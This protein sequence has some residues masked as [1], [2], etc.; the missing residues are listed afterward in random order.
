[1]LIANV[2]ES[3]ARTAHYQPNTRF[4]DLFNIVAHPHVLWVAAQSIILNDGANTPGVDGITGADFSKHQD[5]YTLSLAAELTAGT[6]QPGPVKRVYIPK[7]DGTLRP[8][9]IPTIRDRV[10]QEAVRIALEPIFESHFLNCSTGFRPGRR[11]IDAAHLITRFTNN[12]IKMWWVLEGAINACIDT[13]PQRKLL[14]VLRQYIKDK[15]LLALIQQILGAGIVE[16][17]KVAR[18]NI[19]VS[20]AG[21]ISALLTNVYLHELDKVWWERYGGLEPDQK[22]RRRVEGLGNVQL[23][24]YADDFVLLTNGDKVFASQL[25]AEFSAV[26]ETLGLEIAQ[27]KTHITHIND[28]FDFLGFHFK[29]VYSAMSHKNIVLVTPSAKN[30]AKFKAAVDAITSRSSTGDDPANKLRALNALIRNWAHYYRHVNASDSFKELETYVYWRMYHW[31]K[32]KHSAMSAHRSV[33]AYVVRTYRTKRGKRHVWG[34][35]GVK[36]VPMTSIT[37][38]RYYIKWPEGG[39]PYFNRANQLVTKDD[40]PLPD[41]KQLWRGHS[42]QSAYAVERLKRM[43]QV[44]HKC[45]V[46]GATM[47]LQAHHRKPQQEDGNHTTINLQILCETCHIKTYSDNVLPGPV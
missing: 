38:K 7:A 42:E 29:R 34:I 22:T 15:Q 30:S 24:R 47:R 6:Y 31:L 43:E 40:V 16:K 17:G 44:G 14:G 45:E 5:A 18:P 9:G 23:V 20:Q 11:T 3:L 37:R 1:M 19:G 8:F 35:Y 26:L 28:G 36:L 33:K 12:Q 2:Q 4:D 41:R 21:V 25:R 46:C 27:E 10:V 32:A 13:I 39:N